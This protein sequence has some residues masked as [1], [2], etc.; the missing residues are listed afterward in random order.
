MRTQVFTLSIWLALIGCVDAPSPDGDLEDVPGS[1]KSDGPAQDAA[2]D[3]FPSCDHAPSI[4]V[5]MMTGPLIVGRDAS[6]FVM[7]TVLT[8]SCD[9]F[10]E[11]TPWQETMSTRPIE[12]L[13]F[14]LDPDKS[15]SATTNSASFEYMSGMSCRRYYTTKASLADDGTAAGETTTDEL[16]C[17]T[18]GGFFS[19]SDSSVG[20]KRAVSVTVR[21]GCLTITEAPPQGPAFGQQTWS[22]V[23]TTW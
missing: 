1:G 14:S 15:L 16:G 23:Q 6:N 19:H 11:C 2:D 7:Q 5:A 9:A 17:H 13:W 20:K 3:A 10:G 8:R 18:S 4:P 21:A 12:G 22:S